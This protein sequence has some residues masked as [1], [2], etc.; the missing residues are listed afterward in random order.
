MV[1]DTDPSIAVVA[2]ELGVVQYVEE[3]LGRRLELPQVA[4][5]GRE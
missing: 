3:Q 2:P 4:T 5:G 1:I